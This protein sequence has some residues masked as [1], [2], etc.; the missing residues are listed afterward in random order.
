MNDLLKDFAVLITTHGRPDR[1]LTHTTLRKR[2]YTGRIYLVV[3]DL[4]PTLPQYRERYGDEVIVFDKRKCAETVDKADNLPDLRAVVFARNECFDIAERLGLDVFLQMDDDYNQFRYRFDNQLHYIPGS[5]TAKNLDI[6][7][8]PFVKFMKT[9]PVHCIAMAQGGDFIGGN[10]SGKIRLKSM[11]KMMQTFFLST[12]RRFKFFA[13][14]N[15]DVTTYTY[16]GSIGQ[17]FLT[18]TQ[19]SINQPRTQLV[20][21]GMTELYQEHG[22]YVKSFYSILYHPS[23]IKIRTLEDKLGKRLHHAINWRNTAPKILREEIRKSDE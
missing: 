7:F 16:G 21:G 9:T 17:L 8:A 3:D 1:V 14:M 6:V 22:T 23:S 2:G 4:D 19:F 18:T 13:R 15:D 10:T 20:P 12:K 5:G 11:R